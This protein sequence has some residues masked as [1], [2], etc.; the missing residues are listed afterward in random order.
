MTVEIRRAGL[1]D[2]KLMLDYM[3]EYHK[4]SNM[5]N[6]PVSRISLVKIIEHYIAHKD[7]CP[8]IATDGDTIHGVLF[9][10]LEPYFFNAG[11][12]YATDLMF[13]SKGYGPQLWRKFK[14]WAFAVGADR[15]IMGVSSGDERAGQLLEALGMKQTGGMYVIHQESS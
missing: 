15:I 7:C 8:L 12:N 4:E 6:I 5:S 1:D 3:V 14:D 9:G 11:K 10:S 13:F 2:M